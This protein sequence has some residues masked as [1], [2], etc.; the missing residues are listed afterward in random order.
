M[1]ALSANCIDLNIQ[2]N[3]SYSILKQLAEMAFQNG[4]ITDRPLFLQTL[5]MREKLHSTGFGSGI[6]VPH[7][8]SSCIKY[9]FVLFGRKTQG[10]DWKASDGE[11]VNCWICLGVPQTG[12][13][14][15]VKIIGTLCRKIIHQDF[16]NQLK[17]GDASQVLALLNQT[18]TS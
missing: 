8:K 13:D 10:I 5:L 17:Q 18:L 16:I 6:A 11:A 4:Y 2:G 15:Q 1:S 9:P 3:T 7:G 14:D 12:E